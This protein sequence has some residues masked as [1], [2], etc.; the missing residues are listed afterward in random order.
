[1]GFHERF[2]RQWCSAWHGDAKMNWNRMRGAARNLLSAG[3]PERAI[4]GVS[5]ALRL[6]KP[7]RRAGIRGVFVLR[8]GCAGD[9]FARQ[10]D[11]EYAALGVGAGGDF[12]NEEGG[13]AVRDLDG[14]EFF[15]MA[16]QEAK[17]GYLMPHCLAKMGTLRLLRW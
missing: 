8:V 1:V 3:D 11:F 5:V 14:T 6:P 2:V 15:R 7:D 9:G 4:G 12:R 13:V 17:V 10:V 16:I